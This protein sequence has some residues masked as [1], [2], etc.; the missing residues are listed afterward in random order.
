MYVCG[1]FGLACPTSSGCFRTLA[2]LTIG[3]KCEQVVVLPFFCLSDGRG[4]GGD[5]S[6]G[7][8]LTPPEDVGVGSTIFSTFSDHSAKSCNRL[9]DARVVS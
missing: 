9:L 2:N 4:S 7:S 3:R 6:R 1:F 8:L 5:D